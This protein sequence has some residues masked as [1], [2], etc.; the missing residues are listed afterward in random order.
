M[1]RRDGLS[2]TLP[3]FRDPNEVL[4]RYRHRQAV[5][6]TIQTIA[7]GAIAYAYE[8]RSGTNPGWWL[9]LAAM[10]MYLVGHQFLLTLPQRLDDLLRSNGRVAPFAPDVSYSAITSIASNEADAHPRLVALIGD[11]TA[12]RPRRLNL[13]MELAPGRMILSRAGAR[14]PEGS[15][16]VLGAGELVSVDVVRLVAG[17]GLAVRMRDGTTFALAFVVD[18]TVLTR[19][20]DEWRATPSPAFSFP[21][22]AHSEGFLHPVTP[23][24]TSLPGVDPRTPMRPDHWVAEAPVTERTPNT[25]H[26]RRLGIV[27]LVAFGLVAAVTVPVVAYQTS[28]CGRVHH[29]NDLASEDLNGYFG[30]IDDLR[31]VFPPKGEAPPAVDA[32]GPL[33]PEQIAGSRRDPAAWL[34][35]LRR[36]GFNDAWV[37]HLQS[38]VGL[39]EQVF[40]FRSHQ[41]A[42]D[43]QAWAM[44]SSCGFS[45]RVFTIDGVSSTVG[46]AVN[47][48][49]GTVYQQVSFVRGTRRY[50]I[51]TESSTTRYPVPVI[52]LTGM[53]QRADYYAR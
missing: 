52:P 21:G 24:A 31:T 14:A 18:P 50:L 23:A 25:G 22:A 34:E 53:T 17:S 4:N 38:T 5:A 46:M 37:Q 45:T 8:A 9:S 33:T 43:F 28:G 32:E 49:G 40:Q 16:V 19:E 15:T 35:A 42:L 10:P 20:I 29:L 7:V 47:N 41:G 48:P 2:E 6:L 44:H 39:E 12:R 36:D 11:P 3:P 13:R 26:R 27:L 51:R 30:Q 1:D